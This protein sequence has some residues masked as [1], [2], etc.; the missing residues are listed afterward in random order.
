MY[1]CA[2]V[3]VFFLST[4]L[5][6]SEI[7]PKLLKFDLKNQIMENLLLSYCLFPLDFAGV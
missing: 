6:Y 3:F 7:R 2:C 4:L 5:T 1:V